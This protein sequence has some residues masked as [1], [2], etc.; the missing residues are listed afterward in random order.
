MGPGALGCA[1]IVDE[2]L[3]A[4]DVDKPPSGAWTPFARIRAAAARA[5]FAENSAKPSA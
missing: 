1:L 2:G 4:R 3:T 5:S